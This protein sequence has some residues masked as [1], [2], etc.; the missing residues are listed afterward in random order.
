MNQTKLTDRRRALELLASCPD[1]CPDRLMIERGCSV[2][3]MVDLIQARLATLHTQY[4]RVG[5][6]LM[7][8][9]RLKIT[10]AGLESLAMC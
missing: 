3:L 7:E 8:I 5:P 2:T 10:A 4:M 6:Q 1:G 9:V